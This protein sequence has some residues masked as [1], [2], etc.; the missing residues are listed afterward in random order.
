MC[1]THVSRRVWHYVDC[2]WL[3]RCGYMYLLKYHIIPTSW[4]LFLTTY[5]QLYALTEGI[6]WLSF[7]FLPPFFFF[8]WGLSW[9]LSWLKLCVGGL[10]CYLIMNLLCVFYIV[11]FVYVVLEYGPGWIWI[12]IQVSNY[13]LGLNVW[14]WIWRF[15]IQ[16][17]YGS[18][19][20]SMPHY[21]F[22]LV[23]WL[24]PA[25]GFFVNEHLPYPF[26]NLILW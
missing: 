8:L 13:Y 10:G 1:I 19:I 9:V 23:M 14:G 17:S 21:F 20:R 12:W 11:L 26:F 25:T 4:Q 15:W 3:L 22:L 16:L 6:A 5:I 24:D 7:L 18:I 2:S